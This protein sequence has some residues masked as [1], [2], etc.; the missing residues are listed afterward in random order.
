MFDA[1][2]FNNLNYIKKEPLSGSY[3]GMRYLLEAKKEIVEEEEHKYMVGTVWP[4]PFGYFKTPD[5][6]K[7]VKRFSLDADG[8]ADAVAWLNE[9]YENFRPENFPAD[10][11]SPKAG[12]LEKAAMLSGQ[13]GEAQNGKEEGSTV[14]STEKIKEIEEIKGTEERE[15]EELQETKGTQETEE[16]EETEELQ[17][18][19]GTQE[20]EEQEEAEKLQGTEE[21]DEEI[22]EDE[23]EE[24][25]FD[26]EPEE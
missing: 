17:E 16:R 24:E 7:T 20:T 9:Q 19:K 4:E 13:E 14:S 12:T 25:E 10:K 2:H 1:E 15:A 5:D 11:T 8:I 26:A 21:T 23:E 6:Q 3:K 18:T 22:E